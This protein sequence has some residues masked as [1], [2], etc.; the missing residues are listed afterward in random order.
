MSRR[1][2]SLP[3]ASELG[4]RAHLGAG[5]VG[6]APCRRGVRGLGDPLGDYPRIDWL[7]P[8]R[9]RRDDPPARRSGEQASQEVGNCVTRNRLHG[10]VPWASACSWATLSL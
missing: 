5:D 8:R 2:L 7:Q 3:G 4:E 1:A 6:Q 10:T 9:A